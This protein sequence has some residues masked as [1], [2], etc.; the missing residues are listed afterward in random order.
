MLSAQAFAQLTKEDIRDILML[1]NNYR[2]EDPAAEVNNLYEKYLE[3]ISYKPEDLLEGLGLSALSGVGLGAYE[4]HTFGYTNT[5]WMPKF[6]QNW[7]N[8]SPHVDGEPVYT[9]FSWP[10]VWREVDYASDRAAYEELKLFFKQK[11]YWALLVHWIV[12]NTVA[13]MVR[14]KF[15]HDN[16]MY[17]F[18]LDLVFALPK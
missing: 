15:K 4:S 3:V 9:L 14:D 13:T 18:K 6:L 16:F 10:Q 7:Y 5:G 17:S 8:S 1:E 11:W 2:M 12:K